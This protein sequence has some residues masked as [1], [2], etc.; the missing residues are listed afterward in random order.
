MKRAERVLIALVSV[1][2]LG[3]VLYEGSMAL[4]ISHVEPFCQCC[5]TGCDACP[6]NCE[7]TK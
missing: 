4:A 5:G 2:M 3:C 6:D 1:L 7:A